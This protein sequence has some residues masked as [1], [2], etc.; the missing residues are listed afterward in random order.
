MPK[1]RLLAI[2]DDNDVA[3]MLYVYFVSQG[4]EVLNALTGGDGVTMARAK[5]PNLI[6][7]DIM[8]PDMDGFDVCKT[9]RTTALTRHIPIIFL[10]QR[11]RRADKVTGLELGADDY[12]TKPFDV[13][14]LRLRV[15]GSLRRASREMLTDPRT[16]LPTSA[17]VDEMYRSLQ[18]RDGW[19][20]LKVDIEGFTA[21][22]DTYGFLTADEV[23]T[24]AGQVFAETL[25]AY[26]TKEDFA[27]T[28]AEGRFVIYS[29]LPDLNP[30][31][32]MLAAR[33]AEG[34]QKFYNFA[35]KER[36]YIIINE[37]HDDEQF[38]PLMNFKFIEVEAKPALAP[39][40]KAAN[41]PVL[42]A[43]PESAEASPGA[44]P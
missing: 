6:L 9:L 4:Y 40:N 41:E 27:G 42:R 36:G 32:E 25:T 43:G 31:V 22:R 3:E 35:D 18:F 8:L 16:G 15:Q 44:Q 20:H 26:G 23:L 37:A 39:V 19:T 34:A 11:D 30:L 1:K 17:L 7:L 12:V 14:E 38:I 33:F 10:T 28:W 24:F 29:F 21:F 2:E 13:D 5:S